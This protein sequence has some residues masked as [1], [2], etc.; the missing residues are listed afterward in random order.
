MSVDINLDVNAI[1][2]KLQAIAVEHGPQAVQMAERVIQV[3][4]LGHVI[5]SGIF[6][7]TTTTLAVICG[8]IC[9]HNDESMDNTI[10]IAMAA[11][12]AQ[13]AKDLK[14]WEE[15][16][17]AGHR[18]YGR[19]RPENISRYEIEKALSSVDIKSFDPTV[20]GI[21]CAIFSIV[22][23]IS[24]ICFAHWWSWVN[25]FQPDVGLAHIILNKV[26][27]K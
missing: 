6:F 2:D 26:L 21:M 9:I 17:G 22:A 10:S 11:L 5:V 7:A 25:V 24:A 3:G 1:L 12:A 13:Y 4:S 19:Y 18:V 23:L 27:N 14:T 15:E 8:R 20:F 16:E